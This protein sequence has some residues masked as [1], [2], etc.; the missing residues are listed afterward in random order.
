MRTKPFIASSIR[1]LAVVDSPNDGIPRA[2]WDVTDAIVLRK[3]PS[4]DCTVTVFDAA[5][6]RD[7]HLA[8]LAAQRDNAAIHTDESPPK[9]GPFV[10]LTVHL[11]RPAAPDAS[12]DEVVT[13]NYDGRG[14][15]SGTVEDGIDAWE[16]VLVSDNLWHFGLVRQVEGGYETAN[17]LGGL[18]VWMEPDLI[19]RLRRLMAESGMRFAGGSYISTVIPT[20][21]RAHAVNRF[22]GLFRTFEME[23]DRILFA[24]EAR[25][26][27]RLLAGDSTAMR[28]LSRLAGGGV[29]M[30]SSSAAKRLPSFQLRLGDMEPYKVSGETVDLLFALGLADTLWQSAEGGRYPSAQWHLL[31]ISETGL[32]FLDGDVPAGVVA[33]RREREMPSPTRRLTPMPFVESVQTYADTLSPKI[34]KAIHGGIDMPKSFDIARKADAIGAEHALSMVLIGMLSGVADVTEDGRFRLRKPSA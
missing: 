4:Y 15:M 26:R 9:G 14:R 13:V 11:D 31:K 27:G 24:V 21:D 6:D 28:V 1:R 2:T 10:T 25:Q 12:Y 34:R 22:D 23:V 20:D 16:K 8:D 7:A 32:R 19:E 30:W 5:S 3:P 33:A 18:D 29:L 17:S